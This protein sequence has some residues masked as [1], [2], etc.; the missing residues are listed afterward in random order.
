MGV[1]DPLADWLRHH[2][3]TL[4]F[5]EIER[6]LGRPLPQ[7]ARNDDVWWDNGRAP[8]SRQALAWWVTAVDLKK[9]RVTF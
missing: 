9:E 6:I 2:T 1:Y 4:T 8:R 5:G 7:G 3:V